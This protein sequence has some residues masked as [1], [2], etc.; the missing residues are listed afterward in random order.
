MQNFL[1]HFERFPIITDLPIGPET[2]TKSEENAFNFIPCVTKKE[3][4][5]FASSINKVR[6]TCPQTIRGEDTSNS[7]LEI[8]VASHHPP[9]QQSLQDFVVLTGG[10]SL[11]GFELRT[12]TVVGNFNGLSCFNH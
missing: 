3:V 11:E 5:K 8:L 1:L 9:P 12:S 4:Q 10:K 2:I 6:S 7:V